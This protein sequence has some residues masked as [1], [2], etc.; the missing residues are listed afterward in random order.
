M[1][2]F[3]SQSVMSL[4][5]SSCDVE[6]K[7]DIATCIPDFSHKSPEL[8]KRFTPKCNV[9]VGSRKKSS[10]AFFFQLLA[11]G[12]IHSTKFD[13]QRNRVGK[14]QIRELK[15]AYKKLLC[16]NADGSRQTTW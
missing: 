5:K 2:C 16:L 7:T 4:A 11:Y 15:N 14:G 1:K 12:A 8:V 9:A 6:E 3:I 10:N 13:L